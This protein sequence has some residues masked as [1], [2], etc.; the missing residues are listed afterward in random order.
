MRCLDKK[1]FQGMSSQRGKVFNF[2]RRVAV[3]SPEN[4][5]KHSCQRL[6]VLRRMRFLL[7]FLR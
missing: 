2:L 4:Y 1:G 5:K 7:G 3:R 6:L